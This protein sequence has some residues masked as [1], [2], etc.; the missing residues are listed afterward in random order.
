LLTLQWSAFFV[1]GW[2]SVDGIKSA[3][4]VNCRCFHLRMN[5]FHPSRAGH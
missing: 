2:W 4:R 1:S 5:K 3:C